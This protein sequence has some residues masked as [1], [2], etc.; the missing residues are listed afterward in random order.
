MY[1]RFGR[2]SKMYYFRMSGKSPRLPSARR[3]AALG[4]GPKTK[5]L[6]NRLAPNLGDIPDGR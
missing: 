4:V 5:K 1:I 2:K 6:I 3:R